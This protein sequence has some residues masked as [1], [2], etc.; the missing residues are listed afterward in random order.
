MWTKAK[1]DVSGVMQ[2]KVSECNVGNV[3]NLNA[4]LTLLLREI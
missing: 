1:T 4:L 3:G 2:V